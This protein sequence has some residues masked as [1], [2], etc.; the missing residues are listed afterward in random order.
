MKGNS[1]THYYNLGRECPGSKFTGSVS[2]L[3]PIPQARFQ[4]TKGV[5]RH[6]TQQQRPES[7]TVT[8]PS[9]RVN[10]GYINSTNGTG[11]KE[12]AIHFL[13]ECTTTIISDRTF[14][15]VNLSK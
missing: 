12:D 13:C 5:S 6:G 8:P 3:G 11:K 14:H 7:P 1:E 9:M 4:Q 2:T 15:G 10:T